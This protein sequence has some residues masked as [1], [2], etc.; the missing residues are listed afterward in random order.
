MK[1]LTFGHT[2]ISYGLFPL[3]QTQAETQAEYEVFQEWTF[4]IH[5]LIPPEV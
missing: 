1:Y 5:C 4:L 2:G 3:T